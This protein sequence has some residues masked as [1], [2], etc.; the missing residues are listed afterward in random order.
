MDFEV[1]GPSS[2]ARG[3]PQISPRQNQREGN[4]RAFTPT[5]SLSPWVRAQAGR[6]D[7]EG[8]CTARAPAGLPSQPPQGHH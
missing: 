6:P 7:S 3:A 2:C 1:R 8:R 4:T 5:T